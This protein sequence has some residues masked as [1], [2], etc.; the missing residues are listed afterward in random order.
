MWLWDMLAQGQMIEVPVMPAP[1]LMRDPSL[2]MADDMIRTVRI[3]GERL[4]RGRHEALMLFTVDD[5]DAL[6]L[7]AA[8]LPGQNGEVQRRERNAFIAGLLAFR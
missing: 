1:I 8:F 3:T 7:H 2:V 6:R 4:R 5:G